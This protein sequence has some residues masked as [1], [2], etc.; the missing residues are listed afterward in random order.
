MAPV[1]FNGLHAGLAE[2]HFL[3]L[4]AAGSWGYGRWQSILLGR[5]DYTV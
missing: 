5:W 2:P 4:E 3:Y 1:P